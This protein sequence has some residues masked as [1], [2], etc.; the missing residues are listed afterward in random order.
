VRFEGE[1]TQGQRRL[2]LT[3]PVAWLAVTRNNDKVW[4]AFHVR[5]DVGGS[6]PGRGLMPASSS[7]SETLAFTRTVD[8]AAAQLTTWQEQDTLRLS[9]PWT[10]TLGPRRLLMFV[11]YHAFGEAG[12]RSACDAI[13]SSNTLVFPQ[14]RSQ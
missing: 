11:E 5:V 2:E 12:A 14:P 4:D 9:L 13:F 10:D 8:T 6:L 3:V 1:V 7:Q